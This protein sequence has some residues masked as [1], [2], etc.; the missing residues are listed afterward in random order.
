LPHGIPIAFAWLCARDSNC[1]D[2]SIFWNDH[3]LKDAFTA[4]FMPIYGINALS[5][6][7]AD[8]LPLVVAIGIRCCKCA[9]FCWALTESH[10]NAL[11]H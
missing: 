1:R 10:P 6:I 8:I 7:I 9:A 2:L 3:I 4:I 5:L 11:I